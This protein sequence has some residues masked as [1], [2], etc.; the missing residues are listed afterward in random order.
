MEFYFN[1]LFCGFKDEDDE[2]I[3]KATPVAETETSF[4]QKINMEEPEDEGVEEEEEEIE[5]EFEEED[6]PVEKITREEIKN[7]GHE[8]LEDEVEDES[9]EDVIEE[10]EEE[11]I[12]EEEEE[13]EEDISE[14]VDDSDLMKKLEEK[15]GKLP[16]LEDDQ[17]EGHS[18]DETP[19]TPARKSILLFYNCD[20][21]MPIELML[22]IQF[23][24][25]YF[26]LS[27]FVFCFLLFSYNFM[28][29]MKPFKNAIAVAGRNY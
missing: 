7:I 8:F 21:H 19:V 12:I 29:S 14:E 2:V 13:E 1:S 9:V 25:N 27:L 16:Q 11:D 17:P 5:E 22:P 10:E 18:G 3:V 23:F 15:Y 26:S 24:K 20:F 4:I 28:F 6:E